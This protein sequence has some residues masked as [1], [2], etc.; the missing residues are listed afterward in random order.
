MALASCSSARKYSSNVG[1]GAVQEIF[2]AKA[3]HSARHAAVVATSGFTPSARALAS[4]TGVHLLHFTD[5]AHP[6]RLFGVTNAPSR[7]RPSKV[8]DGQIRRL[9]NSRVKPAYVAGASLAIDLTLIYDINQ[10][11]WGPSLI[12]RPHPSP[13][14][15]AADPSAPA[16][17]VVAPPAQHV[18]Q[19]PQSAS[20]RS[21]DK[22]GRWEG[23]PQQSKAENQGTSATTA[24]GSVSNNKTNDRDSC[25]TEIRFVLWKAN[26]TSG[27]AGPLL[28]TRGLSLR[29]HRAFL[30]SISRSRQGS[31]C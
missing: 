8:T 14:P 9:R 25:R 11:N 13:E 30:S 22:S 24:R 15:K 12:P 27:G 20:P 23:L 5:L 29:R 4:S 21:N 3:H 10:I 7:Y 2:A 17:T 26:S 19:P 16:A 28:P 18:E 1:N 6:N 31:V